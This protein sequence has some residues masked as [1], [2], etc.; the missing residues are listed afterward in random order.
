MA[1][2]TDDETD[3][4]PIYKCCSKKFNGKY[5]VNC[6]SIYHH[7][8]L[9]RD[10]DPAGNKTT[11]LDG[12]H[13]ACCNIT[14]KED[15]AYQKSVDSNK[16][17]KK[18]L[19]ELQEENEKLKKAMEQTK[20]PSKNLT[21]NPATK[22]LETALVQQQKENAMLKKEILDMKN[23]IQQREKDIEKLTAR[24]TESSDNDNNIIKSNVNPTVT[25]NLHLW[26]RLSEELT[27][28]NAL[29]VE[30]NA[31]L[32]D[33]I[34][35]L[36]HQSPRPTYA[37][38]VCNNNNYKST[39]GTIPAAPAP[40]ILIK[41]QDKHVVEKLKNM[42]TE[43]KI[44]GN[45][46]ETNNGQLIV[47]GPN[48]DELEMLSEKIR[49][50]LQISANITE[51]KLKRPRIK[52]T[53]IEMK[54]DQ[55][56]LQ[57]DILGRYKEFSEENFRVMHLY[58]NPRTKK[59]SAI[60]E[61]TRDI[62][63]QIMETRKI[64][65]AYQKCPVYD[66][67]NVRRCFNCCGYNHNKKH[68]DIVVCYKCGG[69]HKSADCTSNQVTCRNCAEANK[70]SGMNLNTDHWAT[71]TK[72]CGVYKKRLRSRSYTQTTPRR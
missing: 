53:N 58:E 28:K 20:Q 41:S 37:G 38:V 57:R 51:H 69:Q 36:K 25:E 13:I 70:K 24:V 40:G 1:G 54:F 19:T 7:S 32:E 21:S 2:G 67:Y 46:V 66:D 65:V 18:K 11:Y 15:E 27:D 39:P 4:A 61:T 3:A 16:N 62:Y 35:S 6:K 63:Q 48:L 49:E 22:K 33:E 8:C 60:I 52:I 10:V 29:L 34:A 30:K 56:A 26:R 31:K 9:T 55:S 50:E 68:C 45:L 71:D 47:K 17:L 72:N 44:K 42:I 5:C 14:S 43:T 64:H 59:I 23:Q 12:V